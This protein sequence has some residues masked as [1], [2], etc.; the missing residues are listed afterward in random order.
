MMTTA[1]THNLTERCRWSSEENRTEPR[2][3]VRPGPAECVFLA[4]LP[5]E[6]T[7]TT[8]TCTLVTLTLFS[9]MINGLMLLGLGR[10]DDL[11]WE[12]RVALLKNLVVSDLMQTLTFGPTVIYSLVQRRTMTFSIWCKAQYYFGTVSIFSSLVTIT[13]MALERYLYICHALSYLVILT[14]QRLRLLLSLIWVYS[15][16]IATAN[17]VL[18]LS[19][20]GKGSEP[21]TK[22]LLCEPDTV[23]QHVGFPRT[24]AVFRK[25]A[26]SFTLLLC[27][28]VYAFSYVRMYRAAR[29]AVVPF[30]AANTTARRTVAFYC[31]MVFVQLL[32]LLL[33]VATDV[34]WEVEGT[35]AFASPSPRDARG[36]AAATG[37]E[38]GKAA[39]LHV[40]LLVLLTVPPCVNPLV[41]GLR[42]AEMRRALT[43]LLRRW[44][45]R[46]NAGARG[47]ADA[48]ADL[49]RANRAQAR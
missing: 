21:F 1:G 36:P 41:Y 6:P 44:T 5:H 7:V 8:L 17:L 47:D 9:F 31:G 23:E 15:L 14:R 19:V 28:L 12:P 3:P 24:S 26:G 11:S 37:A 30:N 40:S 38:S 18:L 22:G 45:R 10:S 2:V 33:K 27:L 35:A 20:Q 29:N 39:V 49:A 25:V 43:D 46:R 16:S 32:P 13:C 4:M 34:L 48:D 42:N